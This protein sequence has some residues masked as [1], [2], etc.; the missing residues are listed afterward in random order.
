MKKLL[1]LLL[2]PLLAFAQTHTGP[3]TLT[4]RQGNANTLD[5]LLSSGGAIITPSASV[6]V[7]AEI[8]LSDVGRIIA[9]VP[10]TVAD[11]TTGAITGTLPA[12]QA[13]VYYLGLYINYA[14]G[15][16]DFRVGVAHI[17]I[18][19]TGSL[20]SV[21][22]AT[23]LNVQITQTKQILD[24]RLDNTPSSGIVAYYAA[25]VRANTA[26]VIS[27]VN[28][29]TSAAQSATAQA[30]IAQSATNQASAFAT[31]AGSSASSAA[32][33]AATATTQAG[34]AT[35]QAG[36]AATLLTTKL[37]YTD[38]TLFVRKLVGYRLLSPAEITKLAATS[39]ANTGD[40]TVA[41]LKTK[42]GIT[43]LSGS[44]TGDQDF[45]GK[46]DV[47]AYNT[48]VTAQSA[49]D[50][51]QNIAISGKLP[52]SYS[53][54]QGTFDAAQST[55]ITG[56]TTQITVNGAS[57]A[58]LTSATATLSTTKLDASIYS[59]FTAVNAA[60]LAAQ[61]V[62]ITA[63]TSA[64]AILNSTVAG[65]KTGTDAHIARTDNPH[66]TIASQVGAYTTGQV[67]A[68]LV[69]VTTAQ[70]IVDATQSAS[71]TGNNIQINSVSIIA[72]N[73][74]PA[75]T[76]A[77]NRTT[78]QGATSA[79]QSTANTALTTANSATATGATN[80]V[81]ITGLTSAT[82]I[83]NSTV[84]AHTTQI[85]SISIGIGT[86]NSNVTT[87]SATVGTNTTQIAGNTTAISGKANTV[88]THSA[89]AVTGGTAG[90]VLT[91]DGTG[92]TWA[93][94]SGG[95]STT[96][97]ATSGSITGAV[98]IST[99]APIST[100]STMKANYYTSGG[101]LN[102]SIYSL[103]GNSVASSAN[104]FAL[105]NSLPGVSSAIF[106]ASGFAIGSGYAGTS[107]VTFRN[108][109]NVL[110]GTTTDVG[111]R[112]DIAQTSTLNSSTNAGFNLTKTVNNSGT[113]GSEVIK[114][115]VIYNTIGS[116]ANNLLLL[117]NGGT[118]KA[119]ILSTGDV[120][121][122]TPTAGFVLKSPDGTCYRTIVVNGGILTTTSITC[123]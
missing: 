40:E 7:T 67:D 41:T 94:V 31:G 24:S 27:S 105:T 43:T 111:N 25:Q 82:A 87:L 3:P 95:A 86:T 114:A 16:P 63:L 29:A 20:A 26:V 122:T 72:S 112:L 77:P 73:A 123:P 66:G 88:H 34:I 65:N 91:S 101:G 93:A 55:S 92:G 37:N 109:G 106:A 59:S 52:A 107:Y 35:T 51:A 102:G 36:I 32:S 10:L 33:S 96:I 76:Y 49:T 2:F 108:N 100:T 98:S 12:L 80:G 44:N 74:L 118:D 120:Y 1:F 90:Q 117:Q 119:R 13:G 58:G 47:S 81:S 45:S 121:V 50:G 22:D 110:V 97:N 14:G 89:S 62:Q 116:G 23:G 42:L 17:E 113:A 104:G 83:L 28:S 75:S 6:S 4:Y 61:A 38:S 56:N 60:N 30:A 70:G 69:S 57:I 11:P 71:I 99:G 18:V 39:N 21:V 54:T 9:S 8:R 85:A 78:D 79:A 5:M 64:T 48:G 53:V 46:L 84:S 103:D 19:P 115:N 68:K 15:E